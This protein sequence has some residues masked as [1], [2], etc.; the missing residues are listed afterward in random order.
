MATGDKGAVRTN[1]GVT[2]AY[3]THGDG[4]AESAL[5]P[6]LGRRRHRLLLERDT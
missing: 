6:W 5:Y 4:H 1:D 2:I 3:T